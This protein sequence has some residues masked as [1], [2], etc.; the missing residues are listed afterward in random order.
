MR[1][2]L[3]T[4]CKKEFEFAESI[5][6]CPFCGTEIYNRET[7]E[8]GEVDETA[9][10][11]RKA[12]KRDMD[13]L[14]IGLFG[15][16]AKALDEM[17]EGIETYMDIMM[18]KA[19]WEVCVRKEK[20]QSYDFFGA[21]G[22]CLEAQSD[23]R[24]FAKTNMAL[25]K[26]ETLIERAPKRTENGEVEMK[27]CHEVLK[28]L[29]ATIFEILKCFRAVQGVALPE[30]LPEF[31]AMRFETKVKVENVSEEACK[32]LLALLRQLLNKLQRYVNEN[33]LYFNYFGDTALIRKKFE[34]DAEK[35]KRM[36]AGAIEKELV[37]DFLEDND[38][39]EKL[40]AVFWNGFY[41]LSVYAEK[42]V[43]QDYFYDGQRC[44]PKHLIETQMKRHY[45][46]ILDMLM[47]VEW[48]MKQEGPWAVREYQMELKGILRAA[49]EREEWEDKR[50]KEC[51]DY[52][53]DN[54]DAKKNVILERT[55]TRLV[56]GE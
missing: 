19:L 26:L 4:Y 29:D 5:L 1:Y 53:D 44:D 24:F 18:D 39:Y 42:N 32:D 30:A 38:T 22:E 47:R 41:Q 14:E 7:G 52:S 35:T 46:T 12:R 20:T 17:R 9:A 36:L 51:D 21:M 25:Q 33:Q 31:P 8:C 10:L 43:E 54:S 45:R 15:D 56:L 49:I 34:K 16:T 6:F 11:Y 55:V 40:L 27:Q 2:Y 13:V 23:E 48:S 37:Y 3:C 28:R 50:D